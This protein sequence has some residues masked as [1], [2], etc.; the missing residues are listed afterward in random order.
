MKWYK[1]YDFEEDGL[2][3]QEIYAV[4]TID[5]K[6]K[7]VC[8][9]RLPDGYFAVDDR[10]PH[11]AGGR[12]GMGKCD[13]DGSVVCPIHRYKYDLKSGKGFQGD[14]VNT[15]QVETRADGVYIGMAGKSWW[16]F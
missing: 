8:L 11:A 2:N 3:P 9:G 14:Y 5:V 15:Y 13:A 10:C 16:P 1:I 6:G 7:M 12:L 4:R